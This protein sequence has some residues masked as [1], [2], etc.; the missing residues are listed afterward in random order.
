MWQKSAQGNGQPTGMKAKSDAMN[1][2]NMG[3]RARDELEERGMN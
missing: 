1:S 3:A 2:Q